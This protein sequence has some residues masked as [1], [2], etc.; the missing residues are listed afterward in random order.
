MT[1]SPFA[2]HAKLAIERA[3]KR[4]GAGWDMLSADMQEALILREAALLVMAQADE[5]KYGAAQA[6]VRAC[7]EACPEGA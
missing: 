6:L 1:P 4:M 3:H 5:D 7:W 2:R